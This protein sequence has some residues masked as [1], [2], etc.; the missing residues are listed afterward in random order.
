MSSKNIKKYKT[1]LLSATANK[2]GGTKPTAPPPR[3][4]KPDPLPGVN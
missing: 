2:S 4:P 3:P 1:N